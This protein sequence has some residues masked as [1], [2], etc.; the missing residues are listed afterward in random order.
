MK[1][2]SD[3][4]Q[5]IA[6]LE[7]KGEYADREKHPVPRV[8]LLDLKMPKV[9]GFEV[10]RWRQKKNLKYLPALVLTSSKLD[11]DL[12]RAYSLG[13]TSYLIKPSE[14]DDLE[15][16]VRSITDYWHRLNEFPPCRE[17]SA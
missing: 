2:V 5:A 17:E 16:L 15:Y 13:A 14:A 4:E 9:D 12:D 6:Y 11:E 7:G 8:L 1:F 10:L 3:G